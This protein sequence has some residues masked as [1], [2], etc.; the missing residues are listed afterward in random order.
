MRVYS[1]DTWQGFIK[2][3]DILVIILKTYS[4]PVHFSKKAEKTDAATQKP[5]KC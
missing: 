2:S 5:E 4:H 3:Y 1:S